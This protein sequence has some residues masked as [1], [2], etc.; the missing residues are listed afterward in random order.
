MTVDDAAATVNVASHFNDADAL[1]YTAMSSDTTKA[2][3]SVSGSVVTITPVAAGTA[4]ITVTA[5]DTASQTATQTIMVTVNAA[6]TTPPFVSA[7]PTSPSNIMMVEIP[8]N[9]FVVLVRNDDDTAALQFPLVPPVGGTAVTKITWSAMPDLHDLFQTTAQ[10]RGGALVLRKSA[11]ARDN[12][13]N[14]ADG[15][16]TNNY[17]TP[18]VGTV[19]ISEIMWARDLGKITVADQAA[20]QWIEL[21]NLNDKPVKVLIYAQK[22][23]DGLIS[24]GQLVNTA[25]GDSLLGNP[26]GM[27]IDAIQNIR[28]D[29]SQTAGGWNVKGKDGNSITG[30]HFASM[31]RILPHQ[32]PDYRNA[33]GSRYNNRKGTHVNHWAESGSVYVRA[34]TPATP[35][36]LFDYRGSPGDVN[37]RTGI[38]ILTPAGRT[39]VSHAITIN[40]VGNNANNSYDWIELKGAAGTNLRNYMI[41]IVTS[42][43]SDSPLVQFPAN[44]NAKI[45]DSGVF[46]ILASDPAN[47]QNHPI[48]PGRNVNRTEV[49]HAQWQWNSPVRYLVQNFSLPNDGKFV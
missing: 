48:A 18:A 45:A 11:D 42:N 35:P 3:V 24:G 29:G 40:E 33:D 19:G 13:V 23:S 27:V 30:D 41:S 34:Q 15:N 16:P 44:D 8:A 28:N 37:A 22:G 49:D 14:D 32:K 6:P 20:G 5:T 1:T 12:Q 46:L 2:T 17:A 9:A 10:N 39:S 4:T 43:S 36:V 7:N 21:Q 26:G 31:H 47:D 38:S 25:A